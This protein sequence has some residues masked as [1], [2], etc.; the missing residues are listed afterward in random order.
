[1]TDTAPDALLLVAPGCPHCHG[2]LEGL[3]ALVEDGTV[4]ALE[5]VDIAVH[6]ERAAELGVRSAPWLRLGDFVIEGAATP[7]ELRRWAEAAVQADGVARYLEQQL[8]DGHLPLVRRLVREHAPWLDTLL[9]FAADPDSPMHLRLGVGALLE[10]L[11][12]SEQLRARL[13]RLAEMSRHPD[14]R[15]RSDACHYLALTASADALPA[16]R[17]RL[18]DEHAEVREIAAESIATLEAA[19]TP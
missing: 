6:P 8:L 14:H 10:E 7:A 19:A 12:G 17:A 11:S 5:V 18:D 13:P 16:L 1:M 3:D 2:V 9:D 15:V 4:G